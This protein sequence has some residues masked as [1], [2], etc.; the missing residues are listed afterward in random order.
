MFQIEFRHD[1]FADGK[2]AEFQLVADG[3]TAQL[4]DRYQLVARLQNGLFGLLGDRVNADF[5]AYLRDQAPAGQLTFLLCCDPRR[6]FFITDLPLDWLGALWL[7]SSEGEKNPSGQIEI[8]PTPGERWAGRGDVVA[9]IRLDLDDLLARG[10]DAYY[11]VD[12]KARELAWQYYLVNRS[13]VILQNPVIVAENGQ[14]FE[15]PES[16]QL[17]SGEQAL[18]FSCADQRFPLRQVPKIVFDLVDRLALSSEEQLVE[19][20]Y[21]KGLPTPGQAQW[22]LSERSSGA[23][24]TLYVYL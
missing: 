9:V 3:P 14:R 2:L 4:L 19:H 11:L 21:I 22:G 10:V 13:E 20:C 7:S 8:S 17:P 5:I 15:G 6:F 24:C 23:V 1:Y 16:F 12:F 18:S